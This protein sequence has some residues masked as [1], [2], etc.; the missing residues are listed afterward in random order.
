MLDVPRRDDGGLAME[1]LSALPIMPGYVRARGGVRVRFA[2]A[3]GRTVRTEVA[4]S[5]GF[6][7]RFPNTFNP[8]CEAVLINTGGGMTGGDA[9]ATSIAVEAGAAAVVTTQAAEKIYRSQGPATEVSTRLKI[10]AGAVLHWL[11]Q[12]AILFGRAHLRR[13]LEAEIAHDATLIAC[14]SVYFG[15]AAM[16]EALDEATLRDHWRIR[17]GGRLIFA[18]DVRLEGR[19]VD[20]LSRPAIAGGARAVATVLM[21]APGAPAR[22]DAARAAL[23]NAVSECGVSGFDGMLIARFLS[24]DAAALRADLARFMINLTGAPLPR[25]WQT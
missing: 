1:Q 23:A 17:R 6:R 14:E 20:I 7:A 19:V 15:R 25:S 4:E 9:L 11:P 10:G 18:E 24:P 5:G 3:G 8:S 16:G 22:L 2:R 12:E 13:H 21:V